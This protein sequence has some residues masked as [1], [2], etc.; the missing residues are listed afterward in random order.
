M[1]A[2]DWVILAPMFVG[3]VDSPGVE[4]ICRSMRN[5]EGPGVEEVCRLMWNV[6]GP[7][8][9]EVCRLMLLDREELIDRQAGIGV[10]ALLS[11]SARD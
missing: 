4:D 11:S 1:C 8:I 3:E 5:I 10:A 7:G 2:A 6:E 9:E